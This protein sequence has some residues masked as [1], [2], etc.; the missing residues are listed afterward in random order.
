MRP[1][2]LFPLF[3]PARSLPGIG[4]RLEKLVEK[5]AGPRVIDLLWHLPSGLID[6]RSRPKIAEV[7]DGEIATIEVTI[8]LHV[9]PRTTRLPYRVHV[10]DETGEM[11]IVFFSPRADYIAKS[12]PEGEKR[13]ISGH[14][15]TRQDDERS[16]PLSQKPNG[17]PK[18][19]EGSTR[20][21]EHNKEKKN[22]WQQ[23]NGDN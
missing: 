10:F 21:G 4:P 1:E 15:L 7:R 22:H 19:P 8:G 6:R 18:K 2:I 23:M 13:I 9:P 14:C 3:S 20:M 16:K 11:Q 5:L 17:N 12:M